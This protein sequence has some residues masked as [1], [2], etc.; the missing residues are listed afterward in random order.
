MSLRLDAIRPVTA[1][2]LRRLHNIRV[3][4]PFRIDSSSFSMLGPFPQNVSSYGGDVDSLTTEI[5]WITGVVFVIAQVL[6]VYMLFRYRKGANARARHFTGEGWQQTKYVLTPVFVVVLLDFYIDVRNSKVWELIKGSVPKAD[7]EVRITG[8]QF[9]WVFTQ[10]GADGKIGT[11][12]DFPSV[13]ELHVPLGATVVFD[14]EAKDVLHSFWVPSLRLKQDAIPGRTI[15]GWFRATQLGTYDIG[16]AEI[17]GTGHS[18]MRA[19]L[20]VHTK[21]D[22]EARWLKPPKLE[23]DPKTI[24]LALLTSKGC[25]GCHTLDG[26]PRVGP[27]YK[28][29]FGRKETVVSN[30]AEKEVVVD[31]AYLRKSILE[32]NS[33]VVKGFAPV[34]PPQ[35]ALLTDA[36]VDAIVAYLKEQN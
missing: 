8:Q 35:R 11:E 16:C 10:P 27:T 34:M 1:Q 12:D 32:P 28:G 30:G 24:G 2:V 14:L 9:A 5:T 17:C 23:G 7:V 31:E 19:V 20:H 36:E 21:E 26:S 33:D 18:T 25:T 22:Y 13:G 4:R 15:K 6:L 29:I 3:A